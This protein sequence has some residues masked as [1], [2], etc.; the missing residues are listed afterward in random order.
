MNKKELKPN[1]NAV[2]VGALDDPL[3]EEITKNTPASNSNQNS[4]HQTLTSNVA[5]TLIP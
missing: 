1:A 4:K 5:I 2:G 3:F